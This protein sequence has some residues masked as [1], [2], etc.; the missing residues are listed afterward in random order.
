MYKIEFYKASESWRDIKTKYAR[1]ENQL[2]ANLYNMQKRGITIQM[3]YYLI[4][5]HDIN[6]NEDKQKQIKNIM[7]SYPEGFYFQIHNDKIEVYPPD[8]IMA[9]IESDIERIGQYESH[10]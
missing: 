2:R 6:P 1:D 9:Y 7:E 4:W 3:I 8:N 10:K 5:V